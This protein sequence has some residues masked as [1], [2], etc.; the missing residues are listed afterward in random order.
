V[1][2]GEICKA[3]GGGSGIRMEQKL[4]L[5]AYKEGDEEGILELSKAVY[6]ERQFD[7]EDWL[8]WWR[9]MYEENPA[10]R[11]WIW[12]AEDNGKLAGQAALV[13]LIVKLGTEIVRVFES[14]DT[15][16]HP[17]YRGRGIYQTLARKVYADAARDKVE[18]GIGFSNDNSYPIA[19]KKL[20][21]I[22][23]P[24]MRVKVRV[25][26]WRNTL[27]LR[28]K[29]S[30]L[31]AIL[32]F[33][34]SVIFYKPLK[35]KQ[36]VEG[37]TI[38]VI[39]T[40]DK[41]FDELWNHVSNQAQI[42][43][44]RDSRYLNWRYG[45]KDSIYTVFAAQKDSKICGYVVFQHKAQGEVKA[46]I[47]FDIIGESESVLNALMSGVVNE[48]RK[49]GDDIIYYSSLNN[50]VYHKALKMSGFMSLPF[51]KGNYFSIYSTS[52]SFSQDFLSNSQN[53]LVHLGDTDEV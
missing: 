8:R 45:L 4:L 9:W 51:V 31:R 20:K 3:S 18:I 28:I 44:V 15:M 41:R 23:M 26:N 17:G 6:P 39:D 7:R 34:A 46:G 24:D 13:P 21:W 36:T 27:K 11:G 22:E 14:I 48:C 29:N 10:G 5:R 49:H 33:G 35:N 30:I 2:Y 32:G 12:L 43:I 42:L 38:S 50:A 16:T 1:G 19:I 47:I 52:P 25:L 37:L 40:F 53:W